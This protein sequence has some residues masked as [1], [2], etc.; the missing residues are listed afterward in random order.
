VLNGRLIS[1]RPGGETPGD[2]PIAA[3][4]PRRVAP[5]RF[6]PMLPL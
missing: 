3:A 6:D 1:A 5:A 4:G 2:E